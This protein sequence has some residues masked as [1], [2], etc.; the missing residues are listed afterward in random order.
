VVASAKI[1]EA[2]SIATRLCTCWQGLT[3]ILNKA[4]ALFKTAPPHWLSVV[5]D[6]WVCG[7]LQP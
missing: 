5:V 3:P 2:N 4:A 6:L 1:A 7:G